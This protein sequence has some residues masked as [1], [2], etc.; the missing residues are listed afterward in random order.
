MF[1]S[2]GDMNGQRNIIN[3]DNVIKVTK[4]DSTKIMLKYTDG[5]TQLFLEDFDDLHDAI[6]TP[7]SD[8]WFKVGEVE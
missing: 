4:Y 5:T 1:V 6:M 7:K 8:Q 3:F 2:L